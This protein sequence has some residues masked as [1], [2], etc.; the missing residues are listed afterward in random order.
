MSKD[1]KNIYL[2][3]YHETSIQPEVAVAPTFRK[4][5]SQISLF[6]KCKKCESISE[7]WKG[8][9]FQDALN[10]LTCEKTCGFNIYKQVLKIV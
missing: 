4:S 5:A 10:Y 3:A 9:A 1:F 8:T 7:I 2:I 6:P